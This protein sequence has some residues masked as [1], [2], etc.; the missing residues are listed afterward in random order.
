MSLRAA[1]ATRAAAPKAKTRAKQRYLRA[2]KVR[3]KARKHAAPKHKDTAQKEPSEESD[4]DEDKDDDD[5]EDEDEDDD[6]DDDEVKES[7]EPTHID[8]MPLQPQVHGEPESGPAPE[9]ALYRFAPPRK[10]ISAD[11]A[12]LATLGIPQGMEAPMVVNPTLTRSLDETTEMC[13]V[14]ISHTVKRQLD[15]LGISEWFAVQASVIPLL[16]NNPA[17]R[18]LYLAYSPPRDFCV[19]AP[20]GSGKTLAYTVPIIEALRSRIVLN[21][22]AVVLVPTRDLALQVFEMFEAVGRGSGLRVAMA[23]GS[24]SFRHEQ[25]QLVGNVGTAEA[26]EYASLVDVLIVTPGR[27]VDHVRGTP[28][29]TLEHLRFLVVDEADRLLGQSFQQWVPVILEAIERDTARPAGYLADDMDTV[30]P[31]VQKLL[32]SATLT[33]DPAKLGALNLRCPQYVNV[34]DNSVEE[35]FAFPPLL[36]EHMIITDSESKV[37]RLISLLHDGAEPVR[38][39][40]C[41]TKSVDAANRLVHLLVSFEEHWSKES[42]ERALCIRFYSSDLTP[43]QRMQM[44]RDF[45]NGSI[46]LL[47]CSD[48]IARGIDLPEVR[49]VVSYDVPV[50]LAKYVHRVGRTARAGRVGDAWTLVEEQEAYHFKQMMRGAG[51]IQHITPYHTDDPTRFMLSYRHAI[52]DLARI[53]SQ[54]VQ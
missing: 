22:R 39:A 46:D 5:D 49:H 28:G 44:L 10:T 32:F 7:E 21:L 9:P 52:A 50:D 19:S 42:G 3:R 30:E 47:V 1:P 36:Q 6:E 29:F 40:L 33:R 53:Y 31:S 48:L 14:E 37:L 18:K 27:L 23:T 38:Q 13:G 8:A 11:P 25:A 20:T 24:H 2:K 15:R 51:R 43:Q 12:E 35:R 16:L 34:G 4:E 26:P 45:R 17:T 41:F 54:H